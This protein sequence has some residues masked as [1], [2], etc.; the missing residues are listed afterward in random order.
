MTLPRS[1]VHKSSVCARRSLPAK[2]TS[3]TVVILDFFLLRQLTWLLN[4]CKKRCRRHHL[5]WCQ[6]SL[7]TA[8]V[9]WR[10]RQQHAAFAVPVSASRAKHKPYPIAV[11]KT[12]S[13]LTS[14]NLRIMAQLLK[15]TSESYVRRSTCAN[16]L[17]QYMSRSFCTLLKFWNSLFSPQIL[18]LRFLTQGSTTLLRFIWSFCLTM[19]RML[20][21]KFV[22]IYTNSIRSRLGDFP[23]SKF[24]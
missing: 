13:K 11:N 10:R 6:K 8:F 22:L 18:R 21:C 9:G 17:M 5:S 4:S 16:F 15:E 24:Q 7:V 12:L 14:Q 23:A 2:R 1:I 20:R 3:P 19:P